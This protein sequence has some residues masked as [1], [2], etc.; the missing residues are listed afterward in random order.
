MR[1]TAS[2]MRRAA[3]TTTGTMRVAWLRLAAAA[4]ARDRTMRACHSAPSRAAHASHGCW[5]V[6]W[7]CAR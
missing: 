3:G 1:T 7:A 5:P 6:S 2:A 4:G